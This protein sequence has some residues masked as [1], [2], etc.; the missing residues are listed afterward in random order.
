MLKISPL[1]D[2]TQKIFCELFCRYYEE[3]GCEDDCGHLLEEYV[4]PDLLA[5]LIKIELIEDGPAYAGFIVYQKDDI[6]NDWNYKEGWG[7]VREIYILPDFRGKG[8]GKFLLY[9]AEM[10]LRESGADRAYCLPAEGS[11]GFFLACGY[12]KTDAYC[13]DL[14][15]F[16]YEKVPLKNGCGKPN[17]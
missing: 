9:T 16:V 2:K 1:N 4:L 12:E 13:D 5:G 17:G 6:D 11:E 7:D 10:K 14:D 15:C 3:L 8:L